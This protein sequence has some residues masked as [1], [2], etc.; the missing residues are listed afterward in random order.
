MSEVPRKYDKENLERFR[1]HLAIKTWADLREP[2][3]SGCWLWNGPK[4]RRKYYSRR[5][6]PTTSRIQPYFYI[7]NDEGFLEKAYAHRFA[8]SIWCGYVPSGM[9]LPFD[10]S[11]K[12]CRSLEEDAD[13]R[14][15][16]VNPFH[17]LPP[18]DTKDPSSVSPSG[19]TPSEEDFMRGKK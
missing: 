11:I 18:T 3:R 16:C 2:N 15:R 14:G 8:Y 13:Y 6:G 7:R 12:T 1:K 4:F 17:R 9:D 5:G 10:L 19:G